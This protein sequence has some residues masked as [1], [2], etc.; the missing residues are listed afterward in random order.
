MKW[1]KDVLKLLENSRRRGSRW[2]RARSEAPSDLGTAHRDLLRR[3][4]YESPLGPFYCDFASSSGI[5]S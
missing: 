5:G 2:A 1:E 4:S 3:H